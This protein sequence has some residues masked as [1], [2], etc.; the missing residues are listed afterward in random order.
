MYIYIHIYIIIY[1]C[2]Y[3][4]IIGTRSDKYF[5]CSIYI[6]IY[7]LFDRS[8]YTLAGAMKEK[9]DRKVYAYHG[10]RIIGAGTDR[11]SR[12]AFIDGRCEKSVP[13]ERLCSFRLLNDNSLRFRFLALS[14]FWMETRIESVRGIKIR[15]YFV[16]E[17]LRYGY[18]LGVPFCSV[19]TF[20]TV[21]SSIKFV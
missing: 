9:G 10:A 15:V 1:I 11:S 4:H 7:S 14:L 20:W 6:Y 21:R 5:G 12:E 13:P 3:V 17:N 18:V 19:W 16:K 2:I 8:T